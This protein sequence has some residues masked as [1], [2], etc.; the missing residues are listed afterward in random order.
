MRKILIAVPVLALGFAA[1][2]DTA[3]FKSQT[4]D[5]IES[6]EVEAQI[7]GEVTDATC[8]EPANTDVG[9]TYTCTGQVEGIGEVT[10][11]STITA[12]DEFE[13]SIQP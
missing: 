10:F 13:V 11:V 3:N 1:C 7:E 12:E 5:F 6:D 9:T 4:E 8:E 2:S